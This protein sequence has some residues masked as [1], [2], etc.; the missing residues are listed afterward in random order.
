MVLIQ[1]RSLI[2]WFG[3]MM[4]TVLL[5][6]GCEQ[7]KETA[8]ETQEEILETVTSAEDA[9][10]ESLAADPESTRS[11]PVP[12]TI[13]Q[14]SPAPAEIAQ[15]EPSEEVTGSDAVPEPP[16]AVTT[17]AA[18]IQLEDAEAVSYESGEEIAAGRWTAAEKAQVTKTLEAL[19]EEFRSGTS[20]ILRAGRMADSEGAFV[21]LAVPDGGIYVGKGGPVVG[22][23]IHEMTHKWEE[24]NLAV[25]KE[26]ESTFSP[27]TSVTSRGKVRATEDLAESVRI[28]VT[29][30][31][32]MK[33]QDPERF[34][35][36]RDKIMKGRTF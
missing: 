33:A 19:P 25:A 5:I 2:L 24:K 30:G 11:V 27:E 20:T 9:L 15:I 35:F 36:I 34:T 7:E 16:P 13:P 17:P 3:A 6:S 21:G 18:N 22:T 14:S 26:W 31:A 28:Y 1:R 32:E 23:M 8:G 10:G 29:K 12:P 4:F